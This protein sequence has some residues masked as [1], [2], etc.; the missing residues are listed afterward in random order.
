M[1]FKR[2][3]PN[4]IAPTD[5]PVEIKGPGIYHRSCKTLPLDSFIE[6]YFNYNFSVLLISGQ[7]DPNEVQHAW[8]EILFDYGR[9]IKSETSDYLF[10]LSKDIALLQWHITY[11]N[12]SVVYLEKQ[13]DEDIA[14]ELR[15]LG[16]VVPQFTDDNYQQGLDRITTLVKRIVFD[17][18][19]LVDEYNRISNIKEGKK[20]SEEDFI[21]TI[22]MLSKHQGYNIDRKTTTV[23]DFTQIFNNYLTEMKVRQ[24]LPI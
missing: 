16:Y 22:M 21:S 15:N 24:K 12:C 10:Q 7:Y 3:L 18:G 20:Q 19:N 1:K 17:H 14:N 4:A 23:F 8:N 9:L 11:V 13:Y 5:I 2:K 6:V